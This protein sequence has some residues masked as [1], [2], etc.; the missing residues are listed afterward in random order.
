MIIDVIVVKGN[1]TQYNQMF[2]KGSMVKCMYEKDIVRNLN[3]IYYVTY[4]ILVLRLLINSLYKVKAS[5]FKARIRSVSLYIVKPY[6]NVVISS[7]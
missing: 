2:T 7:G 4:T 6:N 1:V 5:T 3:I